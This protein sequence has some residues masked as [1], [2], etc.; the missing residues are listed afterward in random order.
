MNSCKAR[1][2]KPD[3]E[4][5]AEVRERSGVARTRLSNEPGLGFRVQ[6]S[7]TPSVRKTERGVL[8]GGG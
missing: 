3:L 8:R 6:R 4:G 7:G 2:R 1:A 5:E